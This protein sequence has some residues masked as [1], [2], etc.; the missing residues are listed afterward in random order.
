MSDAF[1]PCIRIIEPLISLYP[2]ND[3]QLT[4]IG[5]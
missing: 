1:V 4:T 2:P 5:A 3:E